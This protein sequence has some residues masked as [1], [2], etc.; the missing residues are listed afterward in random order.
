M[1]RR[2]NKSSKVPNVKLRPAPANLSRAISEH[3]L[4]E[5]SQAGS[6]DTAV[7]FCPRPF[8]GLLLCATGIKD[9]PTLWK[10]ASELGAANASAFTDRVTHLIADVHG[11]AKYMC[12]LERKIPIMKPSWVEESYDVWLRG[13]D[14]D[15]E[16]SLQAH[17]L[18]IFSGV[19]VCLSGITDVD[20][21][22][23]INRLVTKNGG[24]YVKN[25][26][27][28]VKVTHLLC[29]GDEETEKMRYAE[30][31]NQ[32]KEA[33]IHLVWEEWFWDSLD[34]GGRF[35][36]TRYEVSRPRPER[37]APLEAASSPPPSDFPSE[38]DETTAAPLPSSK[39]QSSSLNHDEDDEVASVKVLPA[40]TL[41][42]WGS[43]LSRRGYQVSGTELVRTAS[44]PAV[45]QTSDDDVQ[46]Q[47]GESVISAFRRANSFAP[48]K[49]DDTE[50]AGSS[51]QPFRR[52]T[53][54]ANVFCQVGDSAA[55]PSSDATKMFVGYRF[56]AL[57]EAKT[58]AVKNAVE[59]YGGRMVSEDDED[60]DFVIVRLVSGS[61][62][63]R[64]ETDS[65]LRS[66]YR[67]EC[68]LE[69]CMFEDRVCPPDQDLSFVPL[70]IETPIPGTE[71]IVLS[72]SGF[73]QAESCGVRRLL[74]A[75][76]ITLAPSFSRNTTHLLCP[77]AT[78]PKFAKA[79]EWGKPVIQMSWLAAIVSTGAI[80]LVEDHLVPGSTVGV[81]EISRL[82]FGVPMEVDVKGKGKA[83]AVPQDLPPLDVG[84]TMNDI[85]NTDIFDSPADLPQ[86]IPSHVR[87]AAPPPPAKPQKT[88]SSSSSSAKSTSSPSAA[89]SFGQPKK[90][91][92]G[93]PTVLVPPT[94]VNSLASIPP[95]SLSIPVSPASVPASVPQH[96]LQ[97]QPQQQQDSVTQSDSSSSTTNNDVIPKAS[98]REIEQD[99]LT[100]KIPSSRTPSPMKLARSGSSRSSIS[101]AKIDHEA[102]KALQES[103]TRALK[104]HTSEEDEVLGG[105]GGGGGRMAKRLRPRGHKAPSR[106]TSASKL[107]AAASTVM[108]MESMPFA[109]TSSI[110]PF[111]SFELGDS[112]MLPIIEPP[113][114]SKKG[115]GLGARQSGRRTRS[116]ALAEEAEGMRVMYEDPALADEKRKLMDLLKTQSQKPDSSP[117]KSAKVGVVESSNGTRRGMRTRKSTRTS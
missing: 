59:S 87:P 82:D 11:G 96:V 94:R 47:P 117:A 43:L 1:R 73:D 32:R 20:R 30:K 53:T 37:K 65:V 6:D 42:I 22:V 51:K 100:A 21:R 54:S 89:I 84:T 85:T 74:R 105:N 44:A 88:R 67:T 71:K 58:P 62:L 35:D 12:A 102:T 78:G 90:G 7:D 83:K 25:I 18:P 104:R 48:A 36:E 109:A 27:R 24:T 81:G 114:G 8:K 26:E 68:W 38:M 10:K 23:E 29:S 49:F 70:G 41:Q 45:F 77:S 63:Y 66:K 56:R 13:D 57:G 40:V 33:V 14:V 93:Q 39:Q 95:Q 92:I 99:K 101:P 116:S 113:A 75:L 28:P 98:W 17:R 3:C 9:K 34:F 50:G 15:Y 112:D 55:G 60:V 97:Q 103:I 61:K 111:D 69:R 4:V 5:E 106:Q 79:C 108:E 52:T 72:F 91:L 110:S 107:K 64:E 76:G 19:V 16:E 46:V 115:A 86:H 80:P 2:T 31:F